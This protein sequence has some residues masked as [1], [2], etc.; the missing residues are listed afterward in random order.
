[1]TRWTALFILSLT[2]S[3][4]AVRAAESE[5]SPPPRLE[6]TDSTPDRLGGLR[7]VAIT[8]VVLEFQTKVFAEYITGRLSKVFLARGNSYSDNVLAGFD[9]KSLELAANQVYDR[10]KADLTAAGY[11]VVPEAEVLAQPLYQKLRAEM[12]WPQGYHF[13]NREGHS[14]IVGPSALPPYLP[15]LGERGTFGNQK[16][17]KGDTQAPKLGMFDAAKMSG[18]SSYAAGW[19]VDLAKALNAH[20]LKA[21]YLIGFGNASAS[22]DWGRQT[23][24][25]ATSHAGA[26]A[27]M[28]LRDEQTR[29]ALRTPDGDRS[30]ARESKRINALTGGYRPFDGDV[31]LRLDESVFGAADFLAEGGV[32]KNDESKGG[33]L[34]MLG[35]AARGL[36]GTVN[37]SSFKTQVEPQR[38]A[39]SATEMVLRL[40]NAFIAKLPR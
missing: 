15:P 35:S 26:S 1:M 36:T 2:V 33:F 19:E 40:Q 10:L 32:Q 14:L 22:T 6:F 13:G 20:V 7:R 27:V 39:D 21:W 3:G 31:V 18:S 16:Q 38:F 28:Y 34:G 25:T 29:I 12:G 8:N 5:P 17:I 11:E 37:D 4:A 23:G 9:P 24:Q 30:Y